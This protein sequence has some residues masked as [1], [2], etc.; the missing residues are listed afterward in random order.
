[1]SNIAENYPWM[2]E[3]RYLGPA[4]V[5]G[6][7]DT[8][9]RVRLRLKG[10]LE[11]AESWATVAING[12]ADL[13]PGDT[14]LVIGEDLNDLYIIGILNQKQIKTS[15]AK[16]ITL[17][18]GTCAE[19]TEMPGTQTLQVRSKKQELLFEYDEKNGKARVNLDSG[20]LEFATKNG[21]IAFVSGRD[22][23]LNGDSV[24]ITSRSGIVMGMMDAFGKIRSSITLKPDKMRLSSP[25]VGINAQCGEIK[26]DETVY[27]GKKFSA[28]VEFSKLVIGRMETVAR[29]VI[30]KA[31][32]VYET[33]EQ[34]SQLKTG[35]L[36]TLVQS[37]Y[38]L[39]SKKSFL[40][41]EQDFKV[42]AEKIH[43]G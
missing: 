42:R 20:D 37:T 26:I 13:N 18:G 6:R 8:G 23:L 40:K 4:Q 1:M 36:R 2:I 31:K 3:T 21:N 16:K 43:L 34:L 27:S 32:N 38:H 19:V 33:V 24:G 25:N 7:D 11:D 5:L 10:A 15:P 41:S 14:A 12:S 39:K 22:I 35:R 30:Q 9:N 29:T 28:K 17:Q